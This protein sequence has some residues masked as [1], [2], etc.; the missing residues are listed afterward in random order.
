[1]PI[2]PNANRNAITQTL[3]NI[4]NPPP[5]QLPPQGARGPQPQMRPPQMASAGPPPPQMPGMAPA[6][7]QGINALAAGPQPGQPRVPLGQV[8]GQ[9][10]NNLQQAP[11]RVANLFTQGASPAAA[12]PLQPDPLQQQQPY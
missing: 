2:N 8:P 1:M 5:R 6:M 12:A 4:Q 11:Q 10:M 9:M 7:T 3:M